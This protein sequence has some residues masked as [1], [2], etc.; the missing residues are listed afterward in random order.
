MGPIPHMHTLKSASAVGKSVVLGR[1]EG[2]S[3]LATKD[4]LLREVC[5]SIHSCLLLWPGTKAAAVTAQQ[6]CVHA[7]LL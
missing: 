2:G 5:Y 1:K 4:E 7:A 6:V 3:V